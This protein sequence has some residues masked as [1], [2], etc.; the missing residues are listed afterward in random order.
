M[1]VTKGAE[2]G[3]LLIDGHKID[4]FVD[5]KL[6]PH[7][8]ES[9]IYFNDYDAFFCASCING[10]SHNVAIKLVITVNTDQLSR[11]IKHLKISVIN[12]DF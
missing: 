9:R 6:C 7:C 5:D 12:D 8:S 3:V 1:K 2:N 4:G 11:W 10:L